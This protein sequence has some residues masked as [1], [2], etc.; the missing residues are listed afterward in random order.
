MFEIHQPNQAMM[1][2]PDREFLS[3]QIMAELASEFDHRQQLLPRGK[4]SALLC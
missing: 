3:Q 1:I 2:G 4:I